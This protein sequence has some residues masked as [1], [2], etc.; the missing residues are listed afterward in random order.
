MRTSRTLTMI[1]ESAGRVRAKSRVPSHLGHQALH[2][3][4][5]GSADHATHQDEHPHDRQQLVRRPAVELIG[6]V[7]DQRQPDQADDQRDG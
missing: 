5:Y 4:L 1:W 2:I 3:G 7:E 6:V